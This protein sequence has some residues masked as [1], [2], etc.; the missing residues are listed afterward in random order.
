VPES[1]RMSSLMCVCVC[2]CACVRVCMCVSVRSGILN[3]LSGLRVM[4]RYGLLLSIL[5]FGQ[6]WNER[7]AGCV[8]VF[9]C[10]CAGGCG[11]GCG[12]V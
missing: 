11:C 8:R 10:G 9:V 3:S 7:K 12:C 1:L 5:R 4:A 6:T 2:V